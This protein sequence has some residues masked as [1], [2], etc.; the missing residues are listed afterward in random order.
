MPLLVAALACLAIVIE[1]VQTLPFLGQG[2][3]RRDFLVGRVIS[4]LCVRV[5]FW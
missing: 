5:T 4:G 1:E 2:N 3:A